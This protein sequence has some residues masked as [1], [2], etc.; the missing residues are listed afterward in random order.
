MQHSGRTVRH[1]R[2]FTLVELLV[3]ITIVSILAV[4]A[5]YG[6]KKVT[7]N[8]KTAEAINML[9]SIMVAQ[10][11]VRN[12]TG[13]YLDVSLGNLAVNN[14]VSNC[15]PPGSPNGQAKISFS[16]WT[17]AAGSVNGNWNALAVTAS[18]PVNYCYTSVA[19]AAGTSPADLAGA[20][21]SVN[22]TAV[23]WP[24]ASNPL[25]TRGPWAI[26]AATL[27]YDGDGTFQSIVLS[28]FQ[29]SPMYDN[30]GE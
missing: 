20:G 26:A 7:A 3:A 5:T 19:G 22:G 16:G 4:L 13:N 2:G 8:G 25:V 1:E 27:D 24:A 30:E 23:A 18:A 11:A 15:Y 10:E 6:F 9:G 28:T 17:G 14:R 21:F 29:N 12:E